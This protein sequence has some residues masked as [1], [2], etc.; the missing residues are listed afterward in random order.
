MIEIQSNRLSAQ[1]NT[2]QCRSLIHVKHLRAKCR[3]M[4]DMAQLDRNT[5]SV[6][7]GKIGA[8]GLDP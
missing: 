1:S 2:G 6:L 4:A 8:S 3:T 5:L 7:T